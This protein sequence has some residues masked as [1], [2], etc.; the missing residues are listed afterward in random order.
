MNIAWTTLIALSSL[1]APVR[2]QE[3]PPGNPQP[4]DNRT[5]VP[6]D[7]LESPMTRGQLANE[8]A[9]GGK[10]AEALEHYLWCWD[11]GLEQDHTYHRVR[12]WLLLPDLKRLAARYPEARLALVERRDKVEKVALAGDWSY[13]TITDFTSLN[14]ALDEPER[15]LEVYETIRRHK[16]EAKPDDKRVDPHAWHRLFESVIDLLADAQRYSDVID[17]AD[18]PAGAVLLGPDRVHYLVE[19]DIS[20]HAQSLLVEPDIPARVFAGREKYDAMVRKRIVAKAAN[21]VEALAGIKDAEEAKVLAN[22]LLDFYPTGPTCAELIR[23]AMRA[24]D[25]KL[26]H[27]IAAAGISKLQEKEHRHIRSALKLEKSR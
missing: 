24:G 18:D 9:R 16:A 26:A 23:H 5:E 11:H 8:L 20:M 2:A 22:R 6:A 13:A 12:L 4:K 10:R 7:A 25:E 19:N 1:A 21:F 27:D 17:G 3:K 15:S 14:G